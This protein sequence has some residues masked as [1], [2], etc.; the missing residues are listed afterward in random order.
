MTEDKSRLS[1]DKQYVTWHIDTGTHKRDYFIPKSRLH[2]TK[3]NHVGMSDELYRDVSDWIAHLSEKRWS[4]KKLLT[5]LCDIIKRCEPDAKINWDNTYRL[6]ND[7][8]K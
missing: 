5:E 7:T 2:E 6:I 4:S 3:H 8:F 1:E